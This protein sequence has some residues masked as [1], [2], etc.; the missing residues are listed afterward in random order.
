[1]CKCR[2]VQ[3]GNDPQGLTPG[4]LESDLTPLVSYVWIGF[5]KWRRHCNCNIYLI[6]CPPVAR[7]SLLFLFI[8][9][10]LL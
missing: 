3:G 10:S 7:T 8:L 9:V 5:F 4:V 1:M 6:F 2:A